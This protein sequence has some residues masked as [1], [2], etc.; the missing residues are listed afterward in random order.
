MPNALLARYF[1]GR[2]L[3]RD[4]DFSAMRETHPDAL[5]PAWLD[6]PDSQ[7]HPMDAEFLDIFELG[8][9]KG[10]RAI[11]DEAEWHLANEPDVLT[12]FVEKLAELSNHYERVWSPS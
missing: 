9:E 7:R 6:L 12:R 11:I 5:F 1:K 4:L 2:E 3:F 10:F 8:C